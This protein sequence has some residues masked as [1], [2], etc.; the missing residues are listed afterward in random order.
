MLLVG[1]SGCLEI[2]TTTTV[3]EDGSLHR[4]V[5]ITGDSLEIAGG[6]YTIPLDDGWTKEIQSIEDQSQRRR[7]RLTAT[8]TFSDVDELNAA[9][10]GEAGKTIE[11]RVLLEKSFRWFTTSYRYSEVYNDFNQFDIVPLTGYAT[12]EE[13]DAVIRSGIAKDSTLPG[14]DSLALQAIEQRLEAWKTRNQFESYYTLLAEGVRRLNDPALP[15]DT[16]AAR[17]EDL[18]AR[19]IGHLFKDDGFYEEEKIAP[20]NRELEKIFGRTRV[21]RALA[22]VKDEFRELRRKYEFQGEVALNRYVASVRMPGAIT[23]TNAVSTEGSTATWSDFM[24]Y[25]YVRDYELWV[26][27]RI[28]NGWAIV[29]TAVVAAGGILLLILGRSRRRRVSVPTA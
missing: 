21:A 26:E 4:T 6:N 11:T 13:A 19:R 7:S 16:L 9:I 12:A 28:T 25:C 23:G 27:S 18:F 15:V 17:K 14:Y 8:R 2:E 20:I 3:N 22:L 29:V 24:P 10:R 1:L 5:V